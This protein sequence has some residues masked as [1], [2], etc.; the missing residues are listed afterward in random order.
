M[1]QFAVDAL[2]SL[3]SS[4]ITGLSSFGVP[5]VPW[6]TQILACQLTLFQLGGTNTVQ[7][8]MSEKKKEIYLI[9]QPR[10][11]LYILDLMVDLAKKLSI[12]L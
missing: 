12:H 11:G 9:L 1:A 2:N 6:H 8:L 10:E 7:N 3:H 5:G 4:F